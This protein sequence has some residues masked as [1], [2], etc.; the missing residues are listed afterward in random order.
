MRELSKK[1]AAA[2][3][4]KIDPRIRSKIARKAA[5]AR[6]RRPRVVEVTPPP[7]PALR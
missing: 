5:K 1:A 4:Q 7:A 6:W 2:R 3:R